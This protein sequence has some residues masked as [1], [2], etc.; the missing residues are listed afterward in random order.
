MRYFVLG[1]N[2]VQ[3]SYDQSSMRLKGI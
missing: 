3:C 1:E 2:P